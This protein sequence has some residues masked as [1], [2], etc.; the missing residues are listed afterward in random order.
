[1]NYFGGD[2]EFFFT[3]RKLKLKK[4][5]FLQMILGAHWNNWVSKSP[6]KRHLYQSMETHIYF[7][8]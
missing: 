8:A 5:T 7:I 1:M 6:L 2:D 3:T 4:T